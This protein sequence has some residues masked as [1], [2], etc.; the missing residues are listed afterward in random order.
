MIRF[1]IVLMGALAAA[2]GVSAPAPASTPAPFDGTWMS[3]ETYRGVEICSYKLLAQRGSR[4]C[5]VQRYFATNAYYEQRL[6]G[7]VSGGVAQIDKICGDPGSETDTYCPGRAPRDAA[8][9]GWAPSK[10]R[11]FQCRGRLFSTSSDAPPSCRGVTRD[12]G[13]PRVRSLG[14]QGP[15]PEDRTWLTACAAGRE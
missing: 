13:I 1:P 9:V 8:K 11:L 15:L 14:G 4:V 5:G 7:T 2:I 12:M 3:C 6:V 10:E